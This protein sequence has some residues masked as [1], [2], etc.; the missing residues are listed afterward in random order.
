VIACPLL[1][2][3]YFTIF[4]ADLQDRLQEEV[5]PPYQAPNDPQLMVDDSEFGTQRGMPFLYALRHEVPKCG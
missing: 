3:A 2:A 4:R 1:T 5:A